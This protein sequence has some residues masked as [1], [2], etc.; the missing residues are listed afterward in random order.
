[1]SRSAR[2]RPGSDAASL[3]PEPAASRSHPAPPRLSV[4][5]EPLSGLQRPQRPEGGGAGLR[6]CGPPALSPCVY[7]EW[8]GRAALGFHGNLF[9]CTFNGNGHIFQA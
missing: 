8:K 5:R 2:A 6:A 1:M 3:S 4:C 9:D 7:G